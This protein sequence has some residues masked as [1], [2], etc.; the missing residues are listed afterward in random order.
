MAGLMREGDRRGARIAMGDGPVL[1]DRGAPMRGKRSSQDPPG[2]IAAAAGH[3]AKPELGGHG[4]RGARRHPER[5]GDHAGR[6]D[7]PRQD[8]LHQGGQL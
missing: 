3:L 1:W 7:R 2:A 5:G 6:G 4:L 8:E